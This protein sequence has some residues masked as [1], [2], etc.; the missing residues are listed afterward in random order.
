MIL[1]LETFNSQHSISNPPSAIRHWTAGW[2][3]RER[4]AL[5]IILP[6]SFGMGRRLPCY[7]V[8]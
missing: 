4:S 7:I 3:K 5:Y 1:R 8:L 6:W 2:L